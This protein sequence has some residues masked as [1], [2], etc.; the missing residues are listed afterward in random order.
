[1]SAIIIWTFRYF[2]IMVTLHLAFWFN[3]HKQLVKKIINMTM[4]CLLLIDALLTLYR[5]FNSM[6]M[7][8]PEFR[9]L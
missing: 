5:Y 7:I 3:L 2:T 9:H 6:L 4:Y 1:M 8:I